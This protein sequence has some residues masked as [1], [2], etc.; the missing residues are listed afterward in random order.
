MT[1]NKLA[2]SLNGTCRFCQQPGGFL[3]RKHGQCC[4]LHATGIQEMTQLVAHAAGTAGF[5][6]TALR[7][8]LQAIATRAYATLQQHLPGHRQRMGLGRKARH[9]GRHP[10]RR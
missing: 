2:Q 3:R 7:S 6:E 8:T 1:L 10:N 9:A 4:D 5:N